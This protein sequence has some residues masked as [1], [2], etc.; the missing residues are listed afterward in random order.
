[1]SSDRSGFIKITC[2]NRTI[3]RVN[4][5]TRHA[6]PLSLQCRFGERYVFGYESGRIDI[7]EKEQ[8]G[9]EPKLNYFKTIELGDYRE[10]TEQVPGPVLDHPCRTEPANVEQRQ[11]KL[12]ETN[13]QLFVPPFN[14]HAVVTAAAD[15][16]HGYIYFGTQEN[17][18]YTFRLV[19]GADRVELKD[20][21]YVSQIQITF[22][23]NIYYHNLFKLFYSET[24]K[25]VI[26][27][28]NR[29]VLNPVTGKVVCEL[30]GRDFNYL[31]QFTPR[32]DVSSATI[33]R[34]TVSEQQLHKLRTDYLNAQEYPILNI[35]QHAQ[36]PGMITSDTC[37]TFWK[38]LTG[39]ELA[40][41]AELSVEKSSGHGYTF[42]ML[43][44]GDCAGNVFRYDLWQLRQPQF[45]FENPCFQE[46]TIPAYVQINRKFMIAPAMTRLTEGSEDQHYKITCTVMQVKH[47][48]ESET[49]EERLGILRNSTRQYFDDLFNYMIRL[50]SNIS[51][52]YLNQSKN[53]AEI[54]NNDAKQV[55]DVRKRLQAELNNLMKQRPRKYNQTDDEI[56]FKKEFIDLFTFDLVVPQYFI[57]AFDAS[58]HGCS[59]SAFNSRLNTKTV[60]NQYATIKCG[61]TSDTYFVVGGY[62]KQLSV[63][64]R[65][66][67]H[68]QFKLVGRNYVV[69]DI[70][71][72][73]IYSDT[74][75]EEPEA[76]QEELAEEWEPEEALEELEEAPEEERVEEKTDSD[77]GGADFF[78]GF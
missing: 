66:D 37:K 68:N 6:D 22:Q 30:Y 28:R 41:P 75:V 17:I 38:Q 42:E 53:T 23:Q 34:C 36:V 4:P 18:V 45:D 57:H 12:P 32:F 14:I 3:Q 35:L 69:S 67:A 43:V 21:T 58:G 73:D 10:D 16:E 25:R 76:E 11:Y 61:C 46:T 40:L 47:V 62:D 15:L 51:G 71:G 39:E 54:F 2:G 48:P 65:D 72:V 5:I 33:E 44:V 78:D 64:R 59:V 50:C 20:V 60:E 74:G 9:L 1:M 31:S 19:F 26:L 13:T 27:L 56:R 52:K 77:A 8:E 24:L 49:V 55:V 70:V 29:Q 63:Y 7:Y